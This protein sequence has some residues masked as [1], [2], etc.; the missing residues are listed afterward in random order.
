MVQAVLTEAEKNKLKTISTVKLA[1]G[2][3]TFL[4][5]EQLKFCYGVLAKD[6]ILQDSEL[7]IETIPAE[8]SCSSCGYSGKIE[9]L[10]TDEFHVR[11]P[12]FTCPKCDEKVEIVKGKDC[13]IKEI[14]GETE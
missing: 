2:E 8:V 10:E 11:L 4:G 7:V 9:Y 5:S 1:V 12:R 6:N 14:S 3:L 13:V